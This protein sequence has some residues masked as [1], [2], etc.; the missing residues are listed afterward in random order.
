MD[1]AHH[2]LSGF[3]GFYT[4]TTLPMLEECRRACGGAG[5]HNF[6]GFTELCQNALPLPTFEG[7]NTVMN[8]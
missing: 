5:F 2:L 3:K 8:L 7:D 1:V 4:D 6:S